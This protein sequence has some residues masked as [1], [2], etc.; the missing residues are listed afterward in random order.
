MAW[1]KNGTPNTLSGAAD[2]I[3]I[4]DLSGVKFNVI[5]SHI[6]SSG[7]TVKK[8]NFNN[9]GIAGTTYAF[10]KN[11]NGTSEGTTTSTGYLDVWPD[12]PNDFFNLTYVFADSS[13]EK[14]AISYTVTRGSAGA[15]N[16]PN[17]KE[18]VGKEV[19]SDALT[20]V[21][22]DNDGA[23]DYSSGSNLS[24]LGTD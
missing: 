16:A 12:Q 22:F 2:E 8:M 5:L 11:S 21:D 20:Q 23:G 13:E 6:I 24:A 15:A 14:L 17:R 19:T 1:A 10:R 3:Q 7:N 9:D 18:V 4:S